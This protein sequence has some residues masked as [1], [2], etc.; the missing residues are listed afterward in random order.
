MNEIWANRLIA[1]SKTWTEMPV[2]RQ[3]PVKKILL[4]RVKENIITAKQ[5]KEIIG[6]EY[7][8]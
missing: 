1:G 2:I 6:E 8:E 3:A 4:E 5:Y 7:T